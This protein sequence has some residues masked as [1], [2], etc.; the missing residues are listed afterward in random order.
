[1]KSFTN[2][3]LGTYAKET[4]VGDKTVNSLSEDINLSNEKLLIVKETRNVWR[5]QVID[6]RLWLMR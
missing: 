3:T 1:M 2:F 4:L 5:R 6:D